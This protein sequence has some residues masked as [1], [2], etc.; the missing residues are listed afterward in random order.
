MELE[1]RNKVYI[2]YD[3]GITDRSE[4]S[5][6]SIPYSTVCAILKRKHEGLP[7]ERMPGSGG[8]SVLTSIDKNRISKI[9]FWYT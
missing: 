2:L 1:N 7:V 8:H 5:R 6:T 9:Y 4:I 3:Y